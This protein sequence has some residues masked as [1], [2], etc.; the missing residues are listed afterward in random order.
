MLLAYCHED[1]E[2]P[3]WVYDKRLCAIFGKP[4]EMSPAAQ[5][6]KGQ[7]LDDGTFVESAIPASQMFGCFACPTPAGSRSTLS[8]L[9]LT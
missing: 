4:T 8:C 1:M 5:S 7:L 3:E 6:K 9:A 2:I